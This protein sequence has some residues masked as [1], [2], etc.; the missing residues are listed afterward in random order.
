MCKRC[1]TPLSPPAVPS[2]LQLLWT[3]ES[4]G[5]WPI[6]PSWGPEVVARVL[7]RDRGWTQS[8]IGGSSPQTADPAEPAA[9]D[10][11]EAFRANGEL[12]PAES[13]DL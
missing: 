10:P 11:A 4:R 9:A 3:P 2:V 6:Q 7:L 5:S 13:V 12:M 8:G 1:E